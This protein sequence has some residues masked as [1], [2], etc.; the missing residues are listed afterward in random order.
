MPRSNPKN[1]LTNVSNRRKQSE[2]AKIS[3]KSLENLKPAFSSTNQPK[4]KNGRKPS[5]LKAYIKDNGLSAADVNAVAKFILP[6]T[7]DEIRELMTDE[8]VP[9]LVR[10]FCRALLEDMKRGQMTNVMNMFDRAF[11][12]PIATQEIRGIDIP[13]VVKIVWTD[14]DDDGRPAET[15]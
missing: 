8:A 10:L 2:G 4:N 6:K 3:P 9:F 13:T 14:S 7:Q 1:P 12:K 5:V 15:V 11:G